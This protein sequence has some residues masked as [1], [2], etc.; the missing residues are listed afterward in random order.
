MYKARVRAGLAL[1]VIVILYGAGAPSG[2][3]RGRAF[4]VIT[5]SVR[6]HQ[7]KPVAGALVSLVQERAT[8]KAI[9]Q[10]LSAA[11][12]SFLARVLPGRYALRAEASGFSTATFGVVQIESADELVYRFNLEP[13]GFGQTAPEK[14]IDRDDP[15]WVLRS[16]QHR[17]SI[18]HV[19]ESEETSAEMVASGIDETNPDAPDTDDTSQKRRPRGVIETYYAA[20]ASDVGG[21]YI[22]T[23]FAFETPVN[24]QFD[25]IFVGQLG[26]L[27]RLEAVTRIRAGDRHRISLKLGGAQLQ[28]VVGRREK[29]DVLGQVSVSAL[30]EWIVRDGVVVVLGFDHTRFI[31]ASNAASTSPRLGVRFD[32]NARTRLKA[33]YASSDDDERAQTVAEFEGGPAV[34]REAGVPAIA[35][36]ENREV[37]EQSRR[38]E[39]GVE[40]VL[41]NNSRV[42]AAAFFD[43]TN[44]RGIGLMSAPVSDLAGENGEA[45]L[46]I[47][48]QQGAARG[49]RVV[50]TRRITSALKASAGYSFGRGQELSPGAITNP[51]QIFRNGFFQTAAA[52]IDAEFGTGTRL[53]TVYRFSPRATVFAI[54]PFAGQLAVYDP[55][56]SVYVTQELPTFGLPVRAE[57]VVDARNLLDAQT[58]ASD[59]DITMFIGQ[60][61]RSVRGGISLKF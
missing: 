51:D 5:G 52:Q 32:V 19:Q 15:K 54:D 26:A 2:F 33:A 40:R 38:L 8:G 41:D 37:M 60:L 27:R 23:N 45:L 31:G 1:L 49:V 36:V 7:G 56:L 9:K 4:G 13:V 6:D 47:A 42:E 34:F 53:R 35:L 55:S 10:T 24:E 28:S 48:N 46:N 50:Y 21:S 58:S 61:R 39:L 3:G 57:A 43:A 59:G 11:D 30:D 14:R 12:G 25:L 20:S 16:K 44:N 29:T 17:R 22:G 18:F